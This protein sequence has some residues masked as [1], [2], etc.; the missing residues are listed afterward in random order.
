MFCCIPATMWVL[1]RGVLHA[2]FAIYTAMLVSAAVP[3]WGSSSGERR[4]GALRSFL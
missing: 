1:L 4:M 3:A 2:G